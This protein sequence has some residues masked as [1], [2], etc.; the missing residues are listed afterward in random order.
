MAIPSALNVDDCTG[1][2]DAAA[3]SNAPRLGLLFVHGIGT[4]QEGV[5]LMQSG[6]PLLEWLRDWLELKGDPEIRQAVLKPSEVSGESRAHAEFLIE[7]LGESPQRIV[8]AESLWAAQFDP[9]PFRELCGWLLGYGAWVALRH[10]C[11]QTPDAMLRWVPFWIRSHLLKL[12]AATAN[13]GAIVVAFVGLIFVVLPLQLFL[14]ALYVLALVPLQAVKD[15]VVRLGVRI[16]EIIGDS[17]VFVSNPLAR[18]AITHKL[19]T[20]LAWLEERCG[21]E[22]PIVI[23]AHSQGAAVAFDALRG[24]RS[25]RPVR[26]ITYGAGIRRLFEIESEIRSDSL[27][28]KLI[29]MVWPIV[30]LAVLAS[31][32]VR[33]DL[34]HIFSLPVAE[35][36]GAYDPD[37]H[38]GILFL[39]GIYLF[40]FVTAGMVGGFGRAAESKVDERLKPEMLRFLEGEVRWRDFVASNDPVP[41]GRLLQSAACVWLEDEAWRSCNGLP[42]TF[43]TSR[44]NNQRSAIADHTSYWGAPDDFIMRV[45]VQL[46]EWAQLG[47]L[48][49]DAVA[50]D[51]AVGTISRTRGVRVGLR[52]A[53]HFLLAVGRSSWPFN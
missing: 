5:T 28:P 6:G 8:L 2:V 17:Y 12:D 34:L 44:V 42:V 25:S 39:L 52:N 3:D 43:G 4:Q 14:V 24:R 50:T 19:L 51:E 10:F 30:L 40:F 22:I 18:A 21:N 45:G 20:D 33:R 31:E 11:T 49:L 29:R 35:M 1:L 23:L 7:P 16:S 53:A 37:A 38:F 47:W 32:A 36:A 41:D 13:L 48:R 9:P 15:W 27:I 46:N 26:L